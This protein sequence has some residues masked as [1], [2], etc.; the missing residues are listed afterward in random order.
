[1]RQ[2]ES[3]RVIRG[4]V[5]PPAFPLIIRPFPTNRSEHIATED[6]GT[7]AFHCT[8][9]ERVIKADFAAL[10][11]RFLANMPEGGLVMCHPGVVDGE[12]ERLDPL[13]T[14]REREYAYLRSDAFPQAL[15][16]AGVTL[17]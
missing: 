7:E 2:Y 1:M 14:L 16:Q 3:W 10:F 5:T 17:H 13:T 11:P 12:L 8:S 15:A 4:I 6:E 9:G